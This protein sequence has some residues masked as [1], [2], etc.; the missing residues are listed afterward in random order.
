[1]ARGAVAKT[2]VEEI[3]KKAF[4]Q[5]FVGISDKK[6]YVSADDGGE[7]VQ[8]AITLT[9]PKVPLNSN[10]DENAFDQN[11]LPTSGSN[12]KPAE[13]TNEETENIKRLMAE[14]GL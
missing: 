2:N 14:L 7:Q 13:I 12:F 3:I 6:L 11:S 9:C 5:N 1:M 10:F 8:I 4:G